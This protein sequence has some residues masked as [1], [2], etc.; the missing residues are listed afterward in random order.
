MKKTRVRNQSLK[1]KTNENKIIHINQRDNFAS[2]LTKT[3]TAFEEIALLKE[4][5]IVSSD[6]SIV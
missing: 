1:N 6:E 3:K 4:N 2:L 5:E